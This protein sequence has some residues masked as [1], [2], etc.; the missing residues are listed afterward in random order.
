MIF[1]TPIYLEVTILFLVWT[2]FLFAFLF[3]KRQNIRTI[4]FINI[5]LL[6]SLITAFWVRSIKIGY[7]SNEK[8]LIYIG[9]DEGHIIKDEI[10]KN[11]VRI[12]DEKNNF[13][14]I[15]Y[16]NEIGWIKKSDISF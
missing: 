15:S 9:P 13:Y 11:R 12:L 7:I 2:L 3:L 16:D 5:V 8:A 10:A 6:L 4:F 14:K 1:F